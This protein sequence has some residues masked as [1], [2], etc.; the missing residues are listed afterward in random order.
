MADDLQ[1]KILSSGI[2]EWNNWR[3]NNRNKDILI[4]LTSADLSVMNLN[5]VDFSEAVL[6][7]ADFYGSSLQGANLSQ[8]KILD[9]NFTL[10]K[11]QGVNLSQSCLS[12]SWM[13][14]ANL[15]MANLSEA[16]LF[17][18]NLLE[19]N[20]TQANLTSS[21]LTMAVLVGANLRGAILN[22]S[23]VYGIS[24]WNVQTDDKTEQNKLLITNFEEPSISVDN[25]EISQFIYLLLRNKGIRSFIDEI[26]SK[27]VL[28][29]GRFT[30]DRKPILDELHIYLRS[31]GDQYV[32]VIFD[33]DCPITRDTHETITTLA[34]MARFVIVDITEPRSVPQELVSIV[35][36]LP[37]LPVQPI[38]MRGHIV[39]GMYDHIRR[40]PW[41]LPICEYSNTDE[42]IQR[43]KNDIIDKVEKQLNS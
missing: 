30:S 5:Y 35:E 6:D 28:L 4:D 43:F 31:L 27:V 15:T 32:P 34:R 24:A 36:Q 33:F 40:Y 3:K 1:L 21:D 37:S 11:M 41:V 23:R 13:T 25:L 8:A 19:A 18:V 38:L 9:C 17:S 2:S 7:G 14:R 12:Q 10:A 26:T 20:L 22:G 39:W 16:D 29:L 42:L